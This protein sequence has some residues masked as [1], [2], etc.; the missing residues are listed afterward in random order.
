MMQS[1]NQE[2]QP[3]GLS[4]KLAGGVMALDVWRRECKKNGSFLDKVGG[5][6]AKRIW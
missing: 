2:Y 5:G 3:W 6:G 1:K 4:R